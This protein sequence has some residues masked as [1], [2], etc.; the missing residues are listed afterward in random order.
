MRKNLWVAITC[1]IV[2]SCIGI[3]A[4]AAT[5]LVDIRA[6]LNK[7]LKFTL[8]GAPWQPKAGE[9]VIYP[10]TYEGSTYLPVRAVAEA[11]DIPIQWDAENYTV[12]IGGTSDKV[13][14]LSESFSLFSATVT[15]DENNRK[16]QGTDH[17][18]VIWFQTVLNS[19]SRFQIEP[20]GQYGKVHLKVGIE[21]DDTEITL[22]NTNTSSQFKTVLISEE[23]GLVDIEADITGMQK[24]MI[25]V[26]TAEPNTKSTVRIVAEQSYYTTE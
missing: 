12:H 6:Q 2:A 8:N 20:A 10:I 14:I 1:L 4:A 21:G 9:T 25:Q 24:I 17:G 19:P 13:P 23:D 3:T 18:E 22:I 5:T 11:M 26:M 7:E 15:A 16:I